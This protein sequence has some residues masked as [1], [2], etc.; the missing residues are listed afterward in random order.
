MGTVL[1]PV[2]GDGSVG[3]GVGSLGLQWQVHPSTCPLHQA[4]WLY[5]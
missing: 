4:T 2:V 5:W 1:E 3:K